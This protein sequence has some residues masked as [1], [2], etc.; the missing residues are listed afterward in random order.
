MNKFTVLFWCVLIT[1]IIYITAAPTDI[2][3]SE[4]EMNKKNYI[5]INDMLFCIN[6]FKEVFKFSTNRLYCSLDTT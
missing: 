4:S 1:I 3:E 6:L 5:E 2:Y